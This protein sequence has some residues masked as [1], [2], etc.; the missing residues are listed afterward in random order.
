MITDENRALLAEILSDCDL[1]PCPSPTAEQLQ[2]SLKQLNH[3][4][5]AKLRHVNDGPIAVA[6]NQSAVKPDIFVS[7]NTAHWKPTVAPLLGDQVKVV[8]MLKF[9]EKIQQMADQNQRTS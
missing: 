9:A 2:G 8:S 7:A 4:M 5:V 1:V 3:Q 6:I